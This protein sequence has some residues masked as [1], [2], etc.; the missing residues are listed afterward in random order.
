[1]F[2]QW[3]PAVSVGL[4]AALVVLAQP[5][6]A[7]TVKITDVELKPVGNNL[8][9]VLK[10]EGGKQMQVLGSRQGSTWVA[11]I[12]NAQLALPQ[13]K[14]TQERPIAGIQS[15]QVAPIPEG[16]VR[17]TVEGTS[18]T[19]A[20]RIGQR[21][22][23]QVSF[24]I[25]PQR[26][27]PAR[28]EQRA[29]PTVAQATTPEPTP[30]PG[31]ASP[32]TIPPN[33]PQGP[34]PLPPVLP[35][36]VAPPVGDI[37]ISQV[38][39]GAEVIDLGPKG[40]TRIPRLVL[41]DAP[42]REVLS[43]IARAAGVNLVFVPDTQ[44]VRV[45]QTQ[46]QE[47]T[48]GFRLETKEEAVQEQETG[49]TTI[50]LDIENEAAQNVLN[51]VLRVAR[52]RANKVGNTLFV[53]RNLPPEADNVIS[54]TLRINQSSVVSLA[55]Y[56]ASQGAEVYRTIFETV[57]E[58]NQVVASPGSPPI[59]QTFPREQ[60]RVERIAAPEGVSNPILQGLR[61]VVDA[62]T[63]AVTLTGPARLV[64]IA[65]GYVAQ[66]DV[67]KR[68]VMVNVKVI[69][70]NLTNT[71]AQGF[72]MSFGVNDTFFRFDNG[73]AI[74]NFGRQAPQGTGSLL[75][76]GFPTGI[77]TP[78][79][80]TPFSP[81]FFAVLQAQIAQNNAKILTDPTLLIQEGETAT[82]QLTADVVTNI[83]VIPATTQGQAPTITVQR[84][85]A[86]LQLAIN[87]ERIDDNGFI[88]L[89]A[90]PDISAPAGTFSVA[91]PG[92]GGSPGAVNQITL[93]AR[94]RVTTG[95]VR[96]RDGQ[97][98]V[99]TGVIQD[100]DRVQASKVPILGDIP[101][102]GALFR[103]TNKV[104]Q[105]NEV[106]VVLTPQIVNETDAAIFNYTPVPAPVG[107]R[108]AVPGQPVSHG[109][110]LLDATGA[111]R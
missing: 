19:I 107:P 13:G 4:G 88:T 75:P 23:N 95:R 64:E 109:G 27:T 89:S 52:L 17:L 72:S 91:T 77:G 5:S 41:R 39:V 48:G 43:L 55:G 62:R 15:V 14:F 26:V 53:G 79:P 51:Y 40:A 16:G 57:L 99:L 32:D 38:N 42:V 74:I 35:R 29:N 68:Q 44:R 31:T 66:L 102:L 24:L 22:D 59:V 20:G 58:T 101:L 8:S 110:P 70:V 60:A 94:R 81:N 1:M 90:S 100:T 45:R 6:Q 34:N 97:P 49:Q 73:A 25:E 33:L 71:Q 96:L 10:T 63:N 65:S 85:P 18:K 56:L 98:L 37:A 80:F 105:R 108:G 30:R 7:A 61:A 104:N 87:V 9:I 82:V 69:D 46:L 2:R 93:L 86:G 3:L 78:G 84:E 36:A 103:S 54:R 67:R 11:E 92:A 76:G 21:A 111:A 12:P 47:V 28:S 50:S 83:Q 106:I